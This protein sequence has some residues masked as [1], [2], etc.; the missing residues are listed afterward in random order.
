MQAKLTGFVAVVL[1]A[2]LAAGCGGSSRLS[3]AQYEQKIQTDGKAVQKAVAS[4][5]GNPGSLKQ[6]AVQVAAAEKAAKTAADDLGSAKPPSEIEVDNATIVA[7][8]RMID[9]QLLKLEQAAKDGDT[10]A[11]QQAATAIQ[12]SPEIQTA[13]AAAKDMKAKGYK[14]GVIG[15]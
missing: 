13:Q 1:L 10:A 12:K 14:I 4:I 2:V 6:L 8:L 5:S 3:K 7:A 9:A 15:S 11:A